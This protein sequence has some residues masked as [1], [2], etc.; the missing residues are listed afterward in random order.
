[1]NLANFITASYF[2]GLEDFKA[3]G[4]DHICESAHVAP[5]S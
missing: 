2:S 1:M 3:A 5:L 4:I